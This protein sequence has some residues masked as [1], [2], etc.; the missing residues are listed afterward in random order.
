MLL[1]DGCIEDMDS[2]LMT[3]MVANL[4]TIVGNDINGNPLKPVEKKSRNAENL[5]YSTFHKLSVFF[6]IKAE[7]EVKT[8]ALFL[9]IFLFELYTYIRICIYDLSCICIHIY[10][11]MSTQYIYIFYLSINM[12]I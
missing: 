8:G 1:S 11:Y 3:T 2:L 7:D 12:N 10:E 6:G 5:L 4:S 9:Y